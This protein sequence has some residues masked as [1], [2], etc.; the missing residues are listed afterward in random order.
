MNKLKCFKQANFLFLL[1]FFHYGLFGQPSLGGYPL[2]IHKTLSLAT[3]ILSLPAINNNYEA[4]RADS[5]SNDECSECLN[6]YYGKGISTF[7]DIRSIGLLDTI[8]VNYTKMW[9]YN[10][11]SSSAYGMQF[12]FDKFHLPFGAKLFIYNEDRSMILGA[13]TSSNNNSDITKAI[14]FGTQWIKGNSIVFEYSEP[15]VPEFE[16]EIRIANVVHIFKDVFDLSGPFAVGGTAPCEENV[17]CYAGF[18]WDKEISSVALVLGFNASLNLS[19]LCSGALINNTNEDGEPYFLSANHCLGNGSTNPIYDYGTWTFLFNHQ[20]L[21]CSS[22][23]SDVSSSVSQSVYGSYLLSN[24]GLGSPTSDYLLLKLNTTKTTLASYGV[25]Y[26]GWD[27]SSSFPSSPFV[28]IHHPKGDIKK[29]ADANAITSISSTHW[30]LNWTTG[31]AEAGSSGSPLFNYNHRI[32][33]QLHKATMVPPVVFPATTQD[34]CDRVIVF[35]YGKFSK[36]WVQGGFSYWLDPIITGQTT[37]DPY[38]PSPPTTIG[39][40]SSGGGSGSTYTCQ[41]KLSRD[42]FMINSN[43]EGIPDVCLS[44][45][46]KVSPTFPNPSYPSLCT[47]SSFPITGSSSGHIWCGTESGTPAYCNTIEGTLGLRCECF[48]W[49]IFMAITEV[50]YNLNP[51]GPEHNGWLS[52]TGADIHDSDGHTLN[53]LS[54]TSALGITLG[55]DKYYKIKLASAESSSWDEKTRYFHTYSNNIYLNGNI[56]TRDVFGHDITLE[57]ITVNE[58]IDVKAK[59]S[60]VILPNSTLNFG[61]YEIDNV[62]CNQF[63]QLIQN[64]I[65]NKNYYTSRPSTFSKNY[66]EKIQ[67]NSKKLMQDNLIVTPNP[68]TGSFTISLNET[69]EN[70]K[71]VKIVIYNMLGTIIWEGKADNQTAFNVDI[72]LQA[73]GVYWLRII[74]DTGKMEVQK[75]IKQ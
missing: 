63:R 48:Y 9:T 14:Q 8:S 50:D 53:L 70:I 29:I 23:G 37:L 3:P 26:A 6:K 57:N 4:T 36:S 15:V 59:N 72:S 61:I 35:T 56:L 19:A 47:S 38:C 13:F 32:I 1:C 69:Q 16:G 73:K 58:M 21:N 17:A 68:N 5:I 10:I 33:G 34:F 60:I 65:I 22:T 67:K 28:G 43:S 41:T 62:E 42:G 46:I 12:Y 55:D 52:L 51:V 74:D 45:G 66:P 11:K 75:I 20:S 54:Y 39:A 31:T 44:E 71:I 40:G 30:G 49:Y 7:I 64:G 27:Y 24:D 25:C 2:T 18:G